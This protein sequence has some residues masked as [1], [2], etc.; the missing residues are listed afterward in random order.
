MPCVSF[1][2]LGRVWLSR[3][4]GGL[5]AGCLIVEGEIEKRKLVWMICV[6]K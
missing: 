1:T 4:L 3:V 5:L 6:V 2:R